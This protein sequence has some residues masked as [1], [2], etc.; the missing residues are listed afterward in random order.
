MD[1]N[2]SAIAYTASVWILP[3]L[4]AITFHEAAHGW[5]AWKLGDYTAYK[6]GRIT[7]NPIKHIDPFG[8]II[9]P[10]L[11]LIGSAGQMMFGFAK[12][13]PVNFNALRNPRR[14]MV[15]VALAGP[16]SNV[17]LAIL[18][19]TLLH[20]TLFLEGDARNW[21]TINLLNAVKINLLLFVF[22]MLPLPP[23][24]GGRVVVGLLPIPLAVKFS[25]LE[26]FGFFILLGALFFLPYIGEKVGIDLN[27]F[28][29]LVGEPTEYLM[30]LF[31]TLFNL[32]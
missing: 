7:F 14:D 25:G 24:D 31:L 12:P 15:L 19:T 10:G 13:V 8:T 17:L 21:V 26:Q 1:L 3:I 27:I 16:L 23:L 4:I 30:I 22:N 2:F 5:A 20:A 32:I 29:W 9:L 28:S 11:L 18:A 6:Q